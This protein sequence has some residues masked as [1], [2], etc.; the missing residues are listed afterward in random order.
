MAEPFLATTLN[1][2][3]VAP[4]AGDQ[5]HNN[6]QPYLTFNFSIALRRVYPPRR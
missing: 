2:N 5:P 6:M 4:A 3:T 1:G